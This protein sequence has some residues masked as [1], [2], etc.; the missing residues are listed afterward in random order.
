[1]L[2]NCSIQTSISWRQ[3]ATTLTA[4]DNF[5]LPQKNSLSIIKGAPSTL[6][7]VVPLY[8]STF[9]H[10]SVPKLTIPVVVSLVRGPLEEGEVIPVEGGSV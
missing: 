8:F 1:M 5:N 10:V 4:I 9:L 7:S 3:R 6:C 2:V